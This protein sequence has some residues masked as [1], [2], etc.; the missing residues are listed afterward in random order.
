MSTVNVYTAK[1]K[2][3][4]LLDRAETGEEVVITRNGRP[5][6]RLVPYRARRATRKLGALKGKIRIGADF[7]AP[8]P[9]DLLAEFEGA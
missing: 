5:V 8:L 6:A 1:A 3:S 9:P 4:S 2:L 7:D